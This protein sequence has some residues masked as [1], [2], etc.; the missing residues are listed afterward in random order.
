MLYKVISA[1]FSTKVDRNQLT[2][3]LKQCVTVF[4]HNMCMSCVITAIQYNTAT[5]WQ[6]AELLGFRI[7]IALGVYHDTHKLYQ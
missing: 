2:S 6:N 4:C 1:D 7:N 5:D 3:K